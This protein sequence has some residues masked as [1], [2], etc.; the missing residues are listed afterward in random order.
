MVPADYQPPHTDAKGKPDIYLLKT[1]NGIIRKR[2]ADGS[3][4][5]LS[6]Q[7]WIAIDGSGNPLNLSMDLKECFDDILPIVN[8]RKKEPDPK[9]RSIT[10]KDIGGD[11]E[12]I[13]E[14]KNIQHR[15]K[16]TPPFTPENV[17][18]LYNMKNGHC[19]LVLKGEASGDKPPISVSSENFEH[20]KT[21]PFD[22]LWSMIT[23][24]K[25]K[26]DRSINDQLQ[27]RQYG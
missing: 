14:V 9:I 13:R 16:Y 11:S 23:T 24:L 10:D 12:M 2:I 22:E 25:Y 20:F 21:R 8:Y 7:E 3:E 15:I 4:W 19:S 17:Q 6:T 1:V 27:D 18:N 5:L 26:L